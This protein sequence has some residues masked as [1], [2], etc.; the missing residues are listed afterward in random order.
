MDFAN[1][2]PLIVTNCIKSI[3]DSFPPFK[4]PYFVEFSG[5]SKGYSRPFIC[6]PYKTVDTLIQMPNSSRFV[7]SK[8]PFA[9]K[10]VIRWSISTYY[11]R[12]HSE[13]KGRVFPK[14]VNP[15]I[16]SAPIA[17]WLSAFPCAKR[18]VVEGHRLAKFQRQFALVGMS[19]RYK[20]MS[21]SDCCS[22]GFCGSDWQ[23]VIVDHSVYLTK[24]QS[25]FR[26]GCHF[27]MIPRRSHSASLRSH[28]SR[29]SSYP[30]YPTVSR[31]PTLSL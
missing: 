29:T 22:A 8:G 21:A 30:S 24:S 16:K 9:Q 4:A 5:A 27:G 1:R 7:A 20:R 28:A 19:K 13:R 11:V 17:D 12:N 14:V 31:V 18:S 6:E 23:S 26:I 3:G 15:R 25:L 2:F 10:F